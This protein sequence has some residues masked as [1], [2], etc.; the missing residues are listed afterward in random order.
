MNNLE[1]VEKYYRAVCDAYALGNVESSY[2]TPIIS[3]FTSIGCAARD[4]SGERSGQVGEN[5]DIKLWHSE[6]EVIE[7]EPFAAIEAKKVGCP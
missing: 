5:I 4:L 7:I 3:L 1:I 6:E 2:Y